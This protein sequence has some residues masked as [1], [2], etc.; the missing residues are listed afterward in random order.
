MS[1][2]RFLCAKVLDGTLQI[3]STFQNVEWLLLPAT[4]PVLTLSFDTYK[5]ATFLL[6]LQRLHFSS[7]FLSY[8]RDAIS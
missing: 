3:T 2:T 1:P 6:I 4:K 7:F 5:P 8:S